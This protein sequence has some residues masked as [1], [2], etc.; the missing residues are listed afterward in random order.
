MNL[1]VLAECASL[2]ALARKGSKKKAI[3]EK[4][5]GAPR[6]N[7]V[8]L[9]RGVMFTLTQARPVLA[10]SH[11]RRN[12]MSDVRG[13]TEVIGKK[14]AGTWRAVR[15]APLKICTTSIGPTNAVCPQRQVRAHPPEMLAMRRGDPHA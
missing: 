3:A 4:T 14:N 2:A 13:K 10:V 1:A 5:T 9:S 8:L 7:F 11:W 15:G 6:T 12:A